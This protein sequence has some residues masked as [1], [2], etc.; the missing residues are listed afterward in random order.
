MQKKEYHVKKG[1]KVKVNTG[2]WKGEEAEIAAVLK[3]KN[4]VVLDIKNLTPQKR[5]QL[6]RRT[7]K[8]TQE[9]PQGGLVPRSLSIHVSNVNPIEESKTPKKEKTKG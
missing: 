3:K 6:G 4:R 5:Q 2:V 7:I 1:D 8:K 9:N